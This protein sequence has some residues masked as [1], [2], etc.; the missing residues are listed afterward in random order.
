MATSS[1]GVRHWLAPDGRPVHHLLDPLTREPARTGLLAVTVAAADPAWT[2]VWTKALFLAGR[3]GIGDEARARDLAA[4]WVT[5]RGPPRDVAR[6]ARPLALGRGGTPRL[7][8]RPARGGS[9]GGR[10]PRVVGRGRLIRSGA[11]GARPPTGSP[12]ASAS[13][14]AVAIPSRAPAR[15]TDSEAATTARRAAVSRS[16]PIASAAAS[17]PLSASPAPV[18]S[19]ALTFGALMSIGLPSRV[20]RTAP[21]EPSDTR[22]A[23]RAPGPSDVVS[24]RV[25]AA[26]IGI[27]AAGGRAA[28]PARILG[29]QARQLPAVR[30]HD[31][32]EREH[33]SIDPVRGRRV[34]HGPRPALA[35]DPERLAGRGRRDLVGHDDDVAVVRFEPPQRGRTCAAVRPAFAPGA[36]AIWFSPSRRRES[37]RPR[38]RCDRA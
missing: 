9:A 7:S 11:A 25:L 1:V 16:S 32:G 29:R 23:L 8:V 21:D 30:R 17:E 15:V 5:E 12:S 13:S 18:A 31:V 20:T 26:R 14:S 10:C 3:R 24:R 19:T 37:G 27:L 22:N 6:G 2:E 35:P 4:W 34:E 36:T 28:G 33:R 38:S